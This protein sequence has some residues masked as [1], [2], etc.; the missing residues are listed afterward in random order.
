MSEVNDMCNETLCKGCTSCN[1]FCLVVNGWSCYQGFGTE[2]GKSVL[3]DRDDEI[4]EE[5]K[6]VRGVK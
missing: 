5:Y 1:E 4:F 2:D 6:K 3:T